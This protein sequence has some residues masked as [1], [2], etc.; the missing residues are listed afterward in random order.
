MCGGIPL[1]F[2]RDPNRS[3]CIQNVARTAVSP[4]PPSR[5]SGLSPVAL[6]NGNPSPGR[7]I[8]GRVSDDE[9]VDDALDD[10]QQAPTVEAG[11]ENVEF[12]GTADALSLTGIVAGEA[13]GVARVKVEIGAVPAAGSRRDPARQRSRAKPLMELLLECDEGKPL[14]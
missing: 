11:L 4:K 8:I 12:V 10:C 13:D 3:R 6:V 2:D 1:A 9:F 14:R 7:A 5:V